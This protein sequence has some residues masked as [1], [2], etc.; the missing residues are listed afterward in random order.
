VGNDA[1]GAQA[2][3]LLNWDKFSTRLWDGPHIDTARAQLFA[4]GPSSVR[5]CQWISTSARIP[6]SPR[7]AGKRTQYG[8]A[9][10]YCGIG[11]H[12]RAGGRSLR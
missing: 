1:A 8:V 10:C 9:G 4:A 3:S 6:G 2:R 12:L 11:I 7:R 5:C